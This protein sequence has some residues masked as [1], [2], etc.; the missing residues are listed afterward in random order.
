MSKNCNIRSILSNALLILVVKPRTAA[1]EGTVAHD[2]SDELLAVRAA[3]LYYDESLTQDEIGARLHVTRWKVGRLLAA[4]RESGI[5]RIR[6]VH[7]RARRVRLESELRERFGLHEAVIVSSEGAVDEPALRRRVAQ[8]AADYLVELAPASLG[9]SWGRT[10]DDVAECLPAA[11]TRGVDVVQINGGLSRADG[12][13]SAAGTVAAIARKGLGTAQ[14]LP[15]PAILE[16]AAIAR[17]LERDRGVAG[18]L[19]RAAGAAAYLFSAGVA[20]EDSAL[21]RSGYL[22]ASEV[23]RL[24]DRGAVGDVVGRFIDAAGS[25]VDHSLDSRTIG[26]PLAALRDADTAVAVLAGEGKHA[27]ARALVCSGLCTC[28]VTDE[29]TARALLGAGEPYTTAAMSASPT[30]E[31]AS[32]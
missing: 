8:A 12:I 25:I 5:V 22:S 27:V 3:E 17:G 29:S 30:H 10:M 24:V 7:P 14:V 26:L 15:I 19:R 18:V 9:V 4:A 32:A 20:S 11:W 13:G 1:R 28:L 6:I 2:D 16:R 31:G 23:A 21:V